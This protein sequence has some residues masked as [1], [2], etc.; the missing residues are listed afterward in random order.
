M[1]RVAARQ[2]GVQF[3]A[4]LAGDEGERLP[5]G[6]S[7]STVRSTGC[8]SCGHTQHALGLVKLEYTRDVLSV[9]VALIDQHS[10]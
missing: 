10:A 4:L 8:V 7:T 6:R 3:G 5:H 9:T 1:E 2:E